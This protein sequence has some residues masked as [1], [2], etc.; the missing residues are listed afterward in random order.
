MQN[1]RDGDLSACLSIQAKI[2]YPA[3]SKITQELA[4][5]LLSMVDADSAKAMA[6]IRQI[7]YYSPNK[8]VEWYY[9]QAIFQLNRKLY[10]TAV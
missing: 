1:L 3:P 4:S 10:L 8:P 6:I 5:E 9:E 2:T 7:M